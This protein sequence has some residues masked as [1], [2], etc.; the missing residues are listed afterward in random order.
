[1]LS[2]GATTNSLIADQIKDRS[3]LDS[4]MQNGEEKSKSL[5]VEK[6]KYPDTESRDLYLKFTAGEFDIKDSESDFFTSR[7][8]IL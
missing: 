3:W 8:Q 5:I 6:S 2:I 7:V 4:Y 1:M